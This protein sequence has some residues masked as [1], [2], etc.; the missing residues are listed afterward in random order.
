MKLRKN[1]YIFSYII[2]MIIVCALNMFSVTDVL[3]ERLNLPLTDNPIYFLITDFIILYILMKKLKT[4][5]YLIQQR[6]MEYFKTLNNLILFILLLVS[7]SFLSIL[8]N[9]ITNIF[10]IYLLRPLTSDPNIKNGVEDYFNKHN[11]DL[12][13]F[14]NNIEEV[15]KEY[16]PLKKEVEVEIPALDVEIKD[17]KKDKKRKIVYT[18]LPIIVITLFL[19]GTIFSVVEIFKTFERAQYNYYDVTLNNEPIHIYYEENFYKV[20]IPIFY[21]QEE[22]KSFYTSKKVEDMTNEITIQ[23]KYILDLKEYECYNNDKGHNVKVSCGHSALSETKEEIELTKNEMIITY[24]NKA[25]YQ[26]EYIQDITDYLNKI[27]KY[28]FTIT[29]KRNEISTEIKFVIEITNEIVEE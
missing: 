9:M 25:I 19:V 23:D 22:S 16:E 1:L 24:E 15:K 27:G 5:S 20:V 8:V 2:C 6:V 14:Y 28:N 12:H 21:T 29:N 26:G 11:R 10:L 13:K 4:E 3:N 18:T 17:T 7:C